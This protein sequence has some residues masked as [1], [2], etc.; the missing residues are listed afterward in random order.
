VRNDWIN[1]QIWLC[2]REFADTFAFSFRSVQ[3]RNFTLGEAIVVWDSFRNDKK[4]KVTAN[5][6]NNQK[7]SII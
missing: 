3:Q 5:S 6:L 4:A 7:L 1:Q 2:F